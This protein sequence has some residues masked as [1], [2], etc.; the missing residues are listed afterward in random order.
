MQCNAMQCNAMQ[1]KAMQCKAIL[2]N[3]MQCNAMQCNAMQ[4]NAMQSYAMQCN[5]MQCNAMQCNAMQCNAM[6]CNAMQYNAMRI[7]E[8]NNVRANCLKR[9]KHRQIIWRWQSEGELSHQRK[10]L[11]ASIRVG[12]IVTLNQKYFFEGFWKKELHKFPYSSHIKTF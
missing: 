1:C 9:G 3:A 11:Q 5:A 8:G 10:H 6:Q 2:C 7:I 4:C 12:I